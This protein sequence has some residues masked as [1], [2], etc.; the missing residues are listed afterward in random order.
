[1]TKWATALLVS[2]LV[3]LV[4]LVTSN[5]LDNETGKKVTR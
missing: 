1:M 5:E 4:V 2:R 3:S